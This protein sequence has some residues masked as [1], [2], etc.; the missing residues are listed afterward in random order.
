ML[1]WQIAP[2]WR[3]D[4]AIDKPVEVT[5]TADGD[6]TVVRLEHRGLEVYGGKAAG[7][8]AIYDS[9]GG[10]TGILA[11]YGAAAEG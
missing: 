5:F 4:P 6:G 10:W 7:V 3:F 1:A 11:L 2:D 8:R 9:E